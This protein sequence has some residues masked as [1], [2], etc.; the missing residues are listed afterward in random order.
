MPILWNR[1]EFLDEADFF[2]GKTWCANTRHNRPVKHKYYYYFSQ[3]VI[4]KC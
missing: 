3:V 4:E 2:D 1:I